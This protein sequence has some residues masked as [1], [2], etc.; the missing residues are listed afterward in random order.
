MKFADIKVNT[1][2]QF[3]FDKNY[4]WEYKK[5]SEDRV[6]CIKCPRTHD[7]IGKVYPV[8]SCLNS[9]VI[10]LTKEVENVKA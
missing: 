5:L 9:K 3:Y 8:G 6:I 10:L 1:K 2:F 4:D 7:C